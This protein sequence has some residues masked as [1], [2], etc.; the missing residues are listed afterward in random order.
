MITFPIEE[1]IFPVKVLPIIN[2]AIKRR[3]TIFFMQLGLMVVKNILIKQGWF[4]IKMGASV[5]ACA[6][7]CAALL[8]EVDCLKYDHKF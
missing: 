8:Q 1:G 2:V 7:P 6:S 5:Q 3:D 4:K